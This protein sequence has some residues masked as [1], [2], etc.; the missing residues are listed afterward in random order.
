MKRIA[1]AEGVPKTPEIHT[2]QLFENAR[3][4]WDETSV[5]KTHVF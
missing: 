2:A 1:I 5:R 4:A 3:P